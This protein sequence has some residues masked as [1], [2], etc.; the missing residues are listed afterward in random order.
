[1][2]YTTFTR[3]T[4]DPKLSWLER[5]LSSAGIAHRRNG[6]SFH[7]PILQVDESK[8]DAAWAILTP[9]DDVPDDDRRFLLG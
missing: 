3:R 9:V 2:K 6:E 7:A 1:M 4:N 5:R 8:L